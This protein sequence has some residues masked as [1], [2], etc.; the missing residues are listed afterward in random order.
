MGKKDIYIVSNYLPTRYV[1]S[2]K[3]KIVTLQGRNL[4]YNIL[5]EQSK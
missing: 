3:A 2:T 5:I 4:L 1:L